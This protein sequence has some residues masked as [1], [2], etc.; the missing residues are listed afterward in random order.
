MKDH[1][2]IDVAL[3]A[4]T[5]GYVKDLLSDAIDGDGPEHEL[6]R[7][8]IKTID[9]SVL[10]DVAMYEWAESRRVFDPLS[11]D[12]PLVLDGTRCEMC[13]EAF[14][15]GS[16]VSILPIEP[17]DEDEAEKA[18]KGMAYNARAVVLHESCVAQTRKGVRHVQG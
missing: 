12:H 6:L 8:V 2:R 4:D 7:D 14:R 5:W 9:E 10:R 1:L 18:R 11:G 16:V 13:G 3:H 17:A 15:A